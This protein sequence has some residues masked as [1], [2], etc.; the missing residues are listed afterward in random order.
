MCSLLMCSFPQF[1]DKFDQ[2]ADA[3]SKAGEVSIK[4]LN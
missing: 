3:L 2:P 4:T 1:L